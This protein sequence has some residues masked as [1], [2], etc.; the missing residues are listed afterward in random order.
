VT[1]R[2][3]LTISLLS[4]ALAVG[5]APAAKAAPGP[6]A[7]ASKACGSF[8]HTYRYRVS[9]SGGLKCASAMRIVKSFIRSHSSW[10][11]HTTDGTVAGT[12]YTHRRYKG[13]RCFEG[14][15]GGSCLRGKRSAGY[16]N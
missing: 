9:A 7:T 12:Y 13:W 15:G 11:E 6:A 3:A 10:R 8:K 5:A 2:S 1:F 16:Q 4:G 14:S